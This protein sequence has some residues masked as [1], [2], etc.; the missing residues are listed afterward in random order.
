MNTRGTVEDRLAVL[1]ENFGPNE[2]LADAV[3]ARISAGPVRIPAAKPTRRWI[4]KS[5]IGLGTAACIAMAALLFQT[6]EQATGFDLPDQDKLQW[7]PLGTMTDHDVKVTPSVAPYTI[8]A[9]LG[10]VQAAGDLAYLTAGQ[11]K[12]LAGNGFLILPSASKEFY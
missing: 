6:S 11:K 12:L 2:A 10:N 8:Q 5:T 7:A 4:M 9:D 3:M 1:A